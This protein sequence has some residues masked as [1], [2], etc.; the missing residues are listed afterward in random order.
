MKPKF[1]ISEALLSGRVTPEAADEIA[2]LLEG[3]PA[4]RTAYMAGAAKRQALAVETAVK[5]KE[6]RP[7]P[8]PRLPHTED[9]WPADCGSRLD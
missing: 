5:M 4:N 1:T 8:G 2:W 7:T 6:W 3:G 9:R